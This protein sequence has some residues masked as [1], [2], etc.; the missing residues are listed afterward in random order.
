MVP[1]VSFIGWHDCGKTTLASQVVRHLK[2]RGY[3][4]AVIKSTKETGIQ[5][6][7]PGT[8]THTHSQAGAD[9]VLLVAP[10]QMVMM[11]G[12]RGES[13]SGL[14]HRY[15]PDV[16]IVIGEGFKNARHVAKIEVFRNSE[17]LLRDRVTGVIAVAS[18][19][20]VSGDY[21]FRLNESAEIASFIEKR[22]LQSGAR[23]S[24]HT[25]LLING[26]RVVMKD[27]VQDALAGSIEG[28]VNALK[29]GEK[30]KGART[31]D[32]RI[33]LPENKLL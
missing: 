9:S 23:T 20:P 18:D 24:D 31:Y 27:F 16:D 7:T 4:V 22:F 21:I 28:F 6:D 14:A 2:K 5:F 32:I 3:T 33:N 10:D 15:F 8:D 11:S 12:N 25:T 29:L 17:Q 26:E 1:I 13:L 30:K 19:E